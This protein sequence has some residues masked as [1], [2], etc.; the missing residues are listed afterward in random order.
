MHNTVYEKLKNDDPEIRK[1]KIL[2]ALESEDLSV[3]F[4][5]ALEN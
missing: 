5:D 2:E 4:D 3:S 1:T